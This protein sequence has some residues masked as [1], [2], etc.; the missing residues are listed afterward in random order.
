[1]GEGL[2]MQETHAQLGGLDARIITAKEN[3]QPELVVILCHGYGA[4]GTDLVPL[5]RELAMSHPELGKI[6]RF[7][8]PEAPLSL[9]QFG[10]YEG[11][12]WWAIDPQR[13][14]RALATGQLEELTDSEP[15]GLRSARAQLQSLLEATLIA[16]GVPLSRVVL[17]GFSQ[18]AMVATDLALRLEDSP[19]GLGIF[20]GTLLCQPTWDQRA[21]LRRDLKIF[22]SHGQQDPL[23]PFELAQRLHQL[24]ISH[25]L[26]ATFHAFHGG[27]TI[28]REALQHFG[29]LLMDVVNNNRTQ[30]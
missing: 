5:A 3:Q 8:F 18:G 10:F 22:Q 15:D 24:F 2:V 26:P 28:D 21:T 27:H 16:T 20:S 19:A 23:L 7:I 1:M 9:G 11:R 4:P 13:F 6:A 17:G 12:A 14:E 30:Q 29:A 25:N